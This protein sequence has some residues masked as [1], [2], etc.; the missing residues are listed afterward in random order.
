MTN[1]INHRFVKWIYNTWTKNEYYDRVSRYLVWILCYRRTPVTSF[2][3]SAVSN[4]NQEV[5]RSY[6]A[7]VPFLFVKWYVP[8]HFQSD[9]AHGYPQ[10]V[11]LGGRHRATAT[12]PVC[13]QPGSTFINRPAVTVNLF[14]PTA[15]KEGV[16]NEFSYARLQ[17]SRVTN[18][19]YVEVMRV[20]MKTLHSECVLLLRGWFLYTLSFNMFRK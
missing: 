19:L 17:V 16:G 6:E 15:F 8:G 5:V 13:H 4:R 20:K 14:L 7:G 2:Q 10:V 1:S 18:T 9:F 11:L 3:C 12:L